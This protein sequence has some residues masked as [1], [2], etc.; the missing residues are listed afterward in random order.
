MAVLSVEGVRKAYQT[1]AG[2]TVA[3]RDI[4]FSME[5]GDFFSLVGPSGCGKSTLLSIIAGTMS[6]T[7]GQVVVAGEPVTGPNPHIGY[8]L[9]QDNLLEWRTVRQNVLFG[10]E[11]RHDLTPETRERADHLL[12]TY[13]LS[14]FANS[15]PSQ[16]SGGMRQRVAL[17]RTLAVNPDILLLD[18]AFS[19]LDYQTRMEVTEDVYRIIR[20]ERVTTLMVTH[21]I[22]ESICMGD[23][24]LILSP[25][26]AVIRQALPITFDLP[27]RSPARCRGL[28]AFASYFDYIWKELG[29]DET[30]EDAVGSLAGESPVSAADQAP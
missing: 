20:R 12:E 18:E 22:P 26:P 23:R 17:I 16:L 6:P 5:R 29:M 10:L 27:V 15:R 19:A 25:R 30:H 13:G 7:A 14:E 8:M 3:L 2:E 4:T 9:Q 24:V 1:P 28:P 11:V 21:D